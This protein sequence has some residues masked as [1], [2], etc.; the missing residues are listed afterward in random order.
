METSAGQFYHGPE[1]SPPRFQWP[2]ECTSEIAQV[3]LMETTCVSQD[4]NVCKTV[5]GF[6]GFLLSVGGSCEQTLGP[7]LCTNTTNADRASAL[8]QLQQQ[9]DIDMV[10]NTSQVAEE[11]I[12]S[13]ANDRVNELVARLMTQADLASD[14]FIL[15]S[16]ISIA[17]G[18]PLVVYK[19]EKGSRIVGATFGLTKASFVM[20]FI[21]GMAIYDSVNVI[22]KET[23]FARLFQNFL[24]DPCYVDPRFSAKRV[25]MIVGVCNNI[26]HIKRESDHLLQK[27][28]G[29]YYNTRLFGFCKDERRKLAKHP[30]L[31]AM[32]EMR[33]QYRSGNISMSSIC[34]ATRLD[35]ETSIAPQGEGVS[36]LKALL[37]SGVLA[38]VVLKFF[39]TSWILHLIAFLEP[40]VMH[41]GKLEVWESKE[42]P[43]LTEEENN[44]VTRFA[45]DKHLLPLIFFSLLLLFEV[46]I[47]IY[48]IATTV[49]GSGDIT[50]WE[51][52]P[53]LEMP[54]LGSCPTSLVPT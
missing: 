6:T 50:T 8:L 23:D 1:K 14:V 12:V 51:G 43:Q 7:D 11:P 30:N 5:G 28:D 44:S 3:S 40:L 47:I 48:S 20:M 24:N 25:E 26:S 17:I 37:G 38:Q 2:D 13:T 19:R 29:V 10:Q 4:V 27:M 18:V 52:F 45:R 53:P 9:R 41:N 39:V 36:K 46:V 15:Y 16:L 31:K 22:S 32:D 34:N 49:N 42:S 54:H 21:I 33:H 35:E